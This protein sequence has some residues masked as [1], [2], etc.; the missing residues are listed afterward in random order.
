M[1]SLIESWRKLE[2]Y[3]QIKESMQKGHAAAVI[4]LPLLP[5]ASCAAAAFEDFG[6]AMLLLCSTEEEAQDLFENLLPLLGDK[7]GLFP[8]LELL[9]FEVYA[10]N[11][12][13]IARR[14]DILNKLAKGENLLV[15]ASVDAVGRR[16]I[17]PE[18]FLRLSLAIKKGYSY[19]IYQLNDILSSMGYERSKLVEIPG[20]YSLRGSILDI[21]P[22]DSQWPAR[23]EFFDDEVESIRYFSPEDQLSRSDTTELSVIPARE[24]PVS[25]EARNRCIDNL[26]AELEKSLE[27]LSGKARKELSDRF[28]PLLELLSQGVWDAGMEQLITMFYPEACTILDYIPQGIAM[29]SEP[30]K[31][32][33]RAGES[34]EV[35]HN[36]YFDLLDAGRLLP[37]FYD[38]FLS[39]MQLAEKLVKHKLLFFAQLPIQNVG[40]DIS[41]V[42]NISAR[43]LPSY[44]NDPEG[45]REAL[46]HYHRQEFRVFFSAS[47]KM[48]LERIKEVL[49][50]LD[51]PG[52]SLLEA[53]FSQGFESS[54]L[55]MALISE[56]ELLAK[57]KRQLRRHRQEDGK[58]INH[59]LD[60][61]VGD[62]VVH[63]AQGIGRYL[64]VERLTAGDTQRD[65]LLIQYAGEDKLYGPVDQLDLI[66]KYSGKEGKTPKINKLGGGEW[67]KVKKRVRQG[68]HEMAKELLA[69]YAERKE[70]QGFAC[71]TDSLWQNEF[72]DAF[73]FPETPDQL[74]AASEIKSDMESILPM[75]R[76]LCG[77]VGY[78][79]T[80]VALRAAFKAVDN[81]KQVA[82]LVPTTVLAQQH[83][84][85]FSQR[86]KNY[87]VNI[88]CLSRFASAKEQK[89]IVE[90][91]ARKKVDIVIGTHRLLSKDVRF[92]DLGLLIVDEEQRFG[93]AHKEKV[94]SLKTN[95]DVL[96]LS[97]TP[98][99]R[100]LHMALVGMRDMSIITSPPEDRHPV[101]T[102]V[103]EFNERL[104]RD[105]IK[106][107]ID[108]EGQVFFVHNR[109]Y[110]IYQMADR[111][112]EL[113][114]QARVIVA[115]GQMQ[116]KDLEKAMLDFVNGFGN[117]LVCTTIIESGLD[118]PNVNT[119]IVNEADSFGLSQL[120]QLRGR[121]GRS[122]RQAYAYFTY[123]KD[124]LI[125]D[126]AKKRLIAIRDFTE[127]GSGFKIAMRDMEIRGAG[128]ILGPEQHGFIADVGFDL[129]CRLLQDEIQRQSGEK[130]M[131]EDFNTL[132]ELQ[133]D[134]Y[135][136]DKYIEDSL[137][138]IEIY[139]RISES[140]EIGEI[141]LLM[142]ELLDR[143]GNLPQPVENLLLLGRSKVYARALH[144]T[145]I[146]KSGEKVEFTFRNDHPLTGADL[147]EAAQKWGRLLA[148]RDKK[149]FTI[150]LQAGKLKDKGLL[151]IVIRFLADLEKFIRKEL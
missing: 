147:V 51:F 25:P 33:K 30:D 17:P 149:E 46:A 108:R 103:M 16:I 97:A 123:R 39:Y 68:I 66:Q 85:T 71:R 35:R 80:E 69:L 44:Y 91:L 109:V 12:E 140:R 28:S 83:L 36:R 70:A 111:I 105:I 88:A 57:E 143:Y 59:F 118:I 117:V 79:K 82:V 146:R 99:P 24:L 4:G 90:K 15:I 145:A 38:N 125:N 48:R 134:A 104:L 58:K 133:L 31:V 76:L 37:S 54:D 72:E 89:T 128:N 130:V 120:Y 56:R 138:K 137:L 121:V 1:Y 114:P 106:R 92:A 2:A 5:L 135:L 53:G 62:Y 119:L 60:L 11:I 43:S 98:I 116:E 20:T 61:E 6:R 144:I 131:E 50:E 122:E 112:A 110:N 65:Y 23:V 47:S 41:P 45:L 73:I 55:G 64:G 8:A 126:I 14:V 96:T 3:P 102:Y 151:D 26:R 63:I 86:F 40:I 124:K 42:F 18:E 22:I 132:V 74:K 95:V 113:L 10:Y 75:D 29:V 21:F 67:Q 94:K 19:D 81:G 93:V 52:V 101:Q 150:I 139:R 148:Y 27:K 77:D 34:E 100:T 32:K 142:G 115:H 136:P 129:Y 78:G 7:A 84:R 9:P 87:P 107:E 49:K 13:L 127:L 141:D